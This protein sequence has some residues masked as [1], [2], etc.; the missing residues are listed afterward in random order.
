MFSE[1]RGCIIIDCLYSIKTSYLR[2]VEN[3]AKNT[4]TCVAFVAF[5]TFFV[6]FLS[7]H[8]SMGIN[9]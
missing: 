9:N 7:F 6:L 8:Y 1:G 3:T 5:V 2:E 4:V